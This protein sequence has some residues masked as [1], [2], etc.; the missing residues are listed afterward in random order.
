M[1]PPLP[2]MPFLSSAALD[3]T[4]L[5][6]RAS[7]LAFAAVA[8]VYSFVL[9]VI[10]V[11]ENR[12][13]ALRGY[14]IRILLMVP[15]YAIAAS[16]VLWGSG[17]VP[18]IRQVL[19][20]VR[21]LYESVVIFSF[22]QFVLTCGSGPDVLV[23]RFAKH[24]QQQRPE[25]DQASRSYCPCRWRRQG[26]ETTATSAPTATTEIGDADA[27]H[28][29]EAAAKADPTGAVYATDAAATAGSQKVR[30][31]DDAE[32]T[33]ERPGGISLGAVVPVASATRSKGQSSANQSVGLG[34]RELTHLPL[35]IRCVPAWRSAR[36]MLRWCVLGTLSYVVVG[37][38]L[39]IVGLIL[40]LVQ[41]ITRGH[42][43]AAND[44]TAAIWETS[45]IALS[46]TQA[47][48]ILS[49]AELAVNMKE[50][51]A[52][53]RP[54]GKFLSVKLVVFFTFW[55]GLLLTLLTRWDGFSLLA[56]ENEE[57]LLYDVLN[58]FLICVE[59]MLASLYHYRVFPAHD[60][61]TLLAQLR[62]GYGVE[63]PAS[64][65]RPICAADVVDIRD[66]YH[67]VVQIHRS[68]SSTAQGL[69]V[70]GASG[71]LFVEAG[72]ASTRLPTAPMQRIQSASA[73]HDDNDKE[74][75]SS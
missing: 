51:L 67:T 56:Q 27:A 41:V 2:A 7:G 24:E 70:G 52:P 12:H 50:E 42:A 75:A 53:M 19:C 61:L 49:L 15:V 31:A 57:V 55:Q 60:Y 64:L 48:A 26:T 14:T 74:A 32:P 71:S 46:L 47:L 6:L 35:F 17:R 38:T 54:Y 20:F 21:E 39:A 5:I 10:H 68:R 28:D 23:E 33:E 62:Y 13:A 69:A 34:V 11:R 4:V 72:V 8:I 25:A 44:V 63:S 58:N 45:G 9:I 66:I 37:A 30:L 43:A 65:G 73:D 29:L 18:L 3:I 22:L 59:M 16:A 36:Q 1:T 40:L